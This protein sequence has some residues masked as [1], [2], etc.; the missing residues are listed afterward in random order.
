MVIARHIR[1]VCVF[2]LRQTYAIISSEPTIRKKESVQWNK[3]KAS[4]AFGDFLLLFLLRLDPK[5]LNVR[6]SIALV[7]YNAPQER[8]QQILSGEARYQV[9]LSFF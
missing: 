8:V 7:K 2:F 4:R 3:Q 1:L 6:H 9:F 5:N